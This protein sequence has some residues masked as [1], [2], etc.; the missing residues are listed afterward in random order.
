MSGE[1]EIYFEAGYSEEMQSSCG[2]VTIIDPR[3]VIQGPCKSSE[4]ENWLITVTQ[5]DMHNPMH[6]YLLQKFK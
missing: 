5:V 2:V 4:K 3:K 1:V 6:D